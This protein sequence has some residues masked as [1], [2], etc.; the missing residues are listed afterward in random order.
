MRKK[1]F[2]FPT[3]WCFYSIAIELTDRC[4]PLSKIVWC[5]P[6]LDRKFDRNTEKLQRTI[7]DVGKQDPALGATGRTATN[8][9]GQSMPNPPFG[10]PS[11]YFE[12]HQNSSKATSRLRR[13]YFHLCT[14][15]AAERGNPSRGCQRETSSSLIISRASFQVLL[16]PRQKHQEHPICFGT[17]GSFHLSTKHNERLSEKYVFCHQ[18][19]LA[20]L[21]I[22]QRPKPGVKAGPGFVQA[23]RAVVDAS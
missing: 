16:C 3:V 9:H 7:T 17:D 4:P 8:S 20:P 11:I 2:E 5:K 6:V 1:C 15:M 13:L 19:G 12:P 23:T 18:F 22:C 21:K 10:M 14:T